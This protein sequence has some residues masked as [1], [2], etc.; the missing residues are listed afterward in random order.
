MSDTPLLY[1]AD[2]PLAEIRLNRPTA[3]NAY[4]E[5][6]IG[7]LIEAL[8]RAA[9]DRAVRAVILTGEGPA[10]C[11]GGDLKRMQARVGMFDG[12]AATLRD[13]Y[14]ALIQ[15]IPRRLARFDVPLIAAVNGPAMGAGLDLA[16]MCDIRIASTRAQF[17]STFVK[18]GLIPGDGGA[19]VLGRTIGLPRAVELIMTGRIIDVAEAERIGLVHAVVEPEALMDVARE[20]ALAIA[21]NPP[22]AVRLAKRAAYRSWDADLEVA[23]ELAAT[24]QGIAQ[25]TEDHAE[26]V[27]A[28]LEKRP[29]RF[30]GR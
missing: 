19:Y 1:R 3:R 27:T 5:P 6:M 23:L 2:G 30:E 18:V 12:D 15:Q 17:G 29:P 14:I 4:S 7:L 16:C 20:R 9:A 26:A 21:A 13:R 25:R 10:F 22:I 24:Y 28:F 8:D 11:A